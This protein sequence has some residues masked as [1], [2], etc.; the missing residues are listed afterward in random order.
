MINNE[1]IEIKCKILNK[2]IKLNNQKLQD[3]NIYNRLCFLICKND[4]EVISYMKSINKINNI[5]Y[6][7]IE[8]K[9]YKKALRSICYLKNLT[10][11]LIKYIELN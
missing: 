11:K 1:Y 9:N 2:I 7:S 8:Y 3:N 4:K 5:I 10:D 6:K